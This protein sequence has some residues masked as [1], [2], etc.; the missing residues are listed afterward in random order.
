[1]VCLIDVNKYRDYLT[2]CMLPG[3]ARAVCGYYIV[4]SLP[5]G[6]WLYV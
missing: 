6:L 3:V 5:Q 1:M 2:L 4:Y